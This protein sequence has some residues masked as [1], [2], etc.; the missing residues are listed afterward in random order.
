MPGDR[1]T[2]SQS[3]VDRAHRLLALQAAYYAVSG[4][5]PLLSRS[6]FETVTGRKHDFWLARLVGL[7]T[8]VIAGVIGLALH[9]ADAGRGERARPVPVEVETLAVSAAAAFAA[10]DATIAWRRG[11]TI[12]YLGDL[13]LQVALIAQTARPRLTARR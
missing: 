5:W 7:L 6:S 4:M 1:P 8:A 3:S 2:P 11:R 9:R 10:V 12:A 13:V